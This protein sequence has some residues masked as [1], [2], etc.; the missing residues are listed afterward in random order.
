M[1]ALTPLN[2]EDESAQAILLGVLAD[3]DLEGLAST[4]WEWW[5]QGRPIQQIML[6]MRDTPE[7]QTR[8]AGLLALRKKGRAITEKEYIGLEKGYTGVMHAAG[9]PTT[10]YDQPDDFAKL[11]SNEV[12]PAEFQDRIAGYTT[13]AHQMPAEVLDQFAAESGYASWAATGWTTSD[14]AAMFIDP[15]KALPAIQQ[16]VQR[17]QIG[18]ASRVTGYGTIDFNDTERL[19]A[20]G[21][22]YDEAMKGFEALTRLTPLFTPLAGADEDEISRQTQLDA[23]FASSAGA[24]REIERRQAQRT[25]VFEG[26]GGVSG[27]QRGS[28]GAGRSR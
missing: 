22:D 6:D 5:K 11:I 28:T 2:R 27:S 13:L 26:G 15:D 23:L 19:R 16:R 25:S 4:V 12:S 8:F 18:G 10:F 1:T 21:V 9:L 14:I 7:Y 24:Q 17:S 20:L 3:M